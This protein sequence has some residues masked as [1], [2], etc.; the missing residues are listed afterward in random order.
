MFLRTSL[1][2]LI[3]AALSPAQGKVFGET[4]VDP[5]AGD[6]TVTTS[7]QTPGNPANPNAAGVILPAAWATTF[8][9][10]NNN[11]P[12]SW[13]PTRYQQVFLGSEIG[14][15]SKVFFSLG[16]RQDDAF[17]GYKG[18]IVDLEIKLGYTTYDHNSLTTNFNNNFNSGTPLTVLKRRSIL[19][20]DMPSSKPTNPATFFIQIGFDIPFAYSYQ[21]GRNLLIEIIQRGNSNNNSLFTYPLDAASGTTTS[22][23]YASG[24]PNAATGTK[25]TG[26]GHIMEFGSTK[27]INKTPGWFSEYGSG[28]QGTGGK[29]GWIVPRA[30]T[31]KWGNTANAWTFGSGPQRWQQEIDASEMPKTPL[32]II[33]FS[34]RDDEAN[35]SASASTL[36]IKM[37]F[38]GTTKTSSTLTNNYANN[39]TGTQTVVFN[40]NVNLP[41]VSGGN[42]NL[43]NFAYVVKLAAPYIY[44]PS[45]KDPNF[46][47]EIVNTTATRVARYPDAFSGTGTPGSRVYANGQPTATTG[48]LNLYHMMAICFG[49]TG[50]NGT[51]TPGISASGRPVINKSFNVQLSAAKASTGAG[52]IIGASDQIW[53]AIKLPFDL[54]I[55]GAT[56]CNLLS[57]VDALIPTAVDAQGNAQI[58]LA[59]PNQT[60]FVGTDLFSQWLVI[61]PQANSFG[62]AFSAGG[63]MAIGDV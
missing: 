4:A 5:S 3:L 32:R 25:G 40:G 62:L 27:I 19:L 57:S 6:P 1:S 34:E 10:T 35:R 7:D 13:S 36:T 23:L 59:L 54:T 39:A 46:L 26:Y 24:N 58:P 63:K 28:C 30:A 12:M 41:A 60:V 43:Q 48:T 44:I 61:D 50:T 18:Q 8:G 38:G 52:L 14:N 17:A 45:S 55:L 20:P 31:S 49:I 51:A 29:P 33:S 11:I 2:I 22:R 56:G 15:A 47:V 42:K 21:Q 53:G 9:N 16:F 37:S